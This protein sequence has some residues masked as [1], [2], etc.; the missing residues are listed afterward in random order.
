[1]C[2]WPVKFPG[3]SCR[4]TVAYILVNVVAFSWSSTVNYQLTSNN[5]LILQ[6]NRHRFRHRP[7]GASGGEGEN[8]PA[9]YQ[10]RLPRQPHD[11]LQ[12][13]QCPEP[14]DRLQ[15]L[16]MT[17]PARRRRRHHRLSV[18]TWA[19]GPGKQCSCRRWCQPRRVGSGG[20]QDR[21]T[22][23]LQGAHNEVNR[24]PGQ[25]GCASPSSLLWSNARPT[26]KMGK[27]HGVPT[28]SDQITTNSYHSTRYWENIAPAV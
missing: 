6:C 20:S 5:Q 21:I 3:S 28:P 12:G 2:N 10:Q 18:D 25:P 7:G 19:R 15:N 22:L 17:S 1:M 14:S 13:P 9:P 23:G 24:E 16:V 4:L 8:P 26:N 27:G 11:P